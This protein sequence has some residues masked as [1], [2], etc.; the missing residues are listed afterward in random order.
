[1][2][3]T[4]FCFAAGLTNVGILGVAAIDIVQIAAVP[5]GFRSKTF[6]SVLVFHVAAV[7]VVGMIVGLRPDA[8]L[9]ILVLYVTAVD[10]GKGRGREPKA[11]GDCNQQGS[12]G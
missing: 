11:H 7:D 6:V 12:E 9:L 1:M 10:L 2:P 3:A 8:F 5:V 4:L